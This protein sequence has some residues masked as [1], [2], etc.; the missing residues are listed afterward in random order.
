MAID[1]LFILLDQPAAQ[2]TIQQP[3]EPQ[4]SNSIDPRPS[5][6]TATPQVYDSPPTAA[7]QETPAPSITN[8]MSRETGDT[9]NV[10]D[11]LWPAYKPWKPTEDGHEW[12]ATLMFN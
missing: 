7:D 12:R 9:M 8:E 2:V 4:V 3:D 10:N 11:Y 1:L 6:D 5:A